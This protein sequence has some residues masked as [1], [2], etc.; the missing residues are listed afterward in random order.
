MSKTTAKQE[1][2]APVLLLVLFSLFMVI[3]FQLG[4]IF[5]LMSMLPTVVAYYVDNSRHQSTFHTVFA[6]NLAGV[7]PFLS[8]MLQGS[9]PGNPTSLIMTDASNWL[10][11]Y[12]AAGFGWLLVF[13]TP[14]AAEFFIRNMHKRQVNRLER[15]QQRISDE[16]GAEV[17]DIKIP[18]AAK[19]N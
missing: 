5:F 15:V 18:S 16:W 8:K 11:V 19:K 17:A 12:L 14:V 4:F 6:C 10:I 13:S 9:G 2:K 3:I 7:L 1:K